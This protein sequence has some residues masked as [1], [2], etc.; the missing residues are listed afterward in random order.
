[1]Y[2]IQNTIIGAVNTITIS[3]A[4]EGEM[5]L[6][7]KCDQKLVQISVVLEERDNCALTLIPI[8]IGLQLK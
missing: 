3:D 2:L 1:M 6:S 8:Q 4:K 7:M 5:S